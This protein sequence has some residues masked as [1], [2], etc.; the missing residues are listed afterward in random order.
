MSEPTTESEPRETA[1]EAARRECEEAFIPW[2]TEYT[3]G[4][5]APSQE[6]YATAYWISVARLVLTG[7]DEWLAESAKARA[8]AE[9]DRQADRETAKADKDKQE[10]DRRTINRFTG[11]IML[12]TAI[13]AFGTYWA[14]FHPSKPIVL[15][16][17]I[18][19]TATPDLRW[20]S[21]SAPSVTK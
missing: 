18:V 6:G 10:R 4:A 21:C 19:Y 8:S 14:A 20:S 12:A 17:T 16:S 13:S 2:R 9:A 5:R 11:V 15:P 3:R 1:Y 7:L